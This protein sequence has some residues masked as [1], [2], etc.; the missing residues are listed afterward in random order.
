MPQNYYETLG[1]KKDASADEIK[2]AYRK[3]AHKYHPDK[4]QGAN[5]ENDAKFKEVNEAYQV[6]SDSEKKSQYDQYGQTFED[7]QRQG[8]GPGY[9]A[10]FGGQGGNP[11]GGGQ[12]PFGGF[13]GGV[14][15]DFGDIFG[16][17]FG[18]RGQ[19]SERRNRGIDLEMPL[20]ISFEDAVFGVKR[21]ITLEKKDKCKT[22]DGSGAKPGTKVVTCPVCH[23]Q[24]QI[25]T[26]RN[27]IFGAVQSA[28]ACDRC[29][30]DGKIPEVPCETCKGEGF[31]RQEKTLEV[32]IPAGIDNN[33]RIRI[34][35]E[36]EVGYRGSQPGDLY[37]NIR[38]K[39]HKEF[40]RDGTTL[41]TSVP[42]SFTQA[43]LGAKVKVQT[44][45]GEIELKIPAGTQPGKVFKVA[46]KGV[47]DLD[48]RSHGA[49]GKRGDLLITARVVIPNKLS[50][51]ETEL[52]KQIAELEGETVEVNKSF[53]ESIKD[54]F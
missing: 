50:K 34:N 15:F 18:S 47:P 17:I 7:A 10:G 41:R 13:A 2:K 25:K 30:G 33:Q 1:I 16:D 51:K 45:D 21:N 22:C 11:F 48:H 37:I 32:Q 26:Q 43:A 42:I 5:S 27:T 36:G 29:G 31:F 52:M 49:G 40:V 46:G 24:G 6:L 44:L 19:R 14:D 4:G 54:S 3:L 28:V 38:V 20:T 9:G 53:W 12:N 8:G 35:G 23:G 39:P